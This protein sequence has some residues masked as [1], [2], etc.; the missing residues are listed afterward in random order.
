M[1]QKQPTLVIMAA[2]MGSRYGGLKQIDPVDN[3][4]NKIIDFSIYDAVQAGFAKV[5][6]II[7]EENQEAFNEAIADRLRG[8]VDIEFAYQKLED[9]PEGCKVPEGRVKPWGTAQAVLAARNLIDGPFAVINADDFYGREAFVKMH[10]FLVN[11]EDDEKYRYAMV[12]FI[13]K[14]TL[15]DNGYVSRGICTVSPENYLVSV[16]EHTHIEKDGEAAKYTEDDGKTW[17]SFSGNET[18]SMNFWGFGKSIVPELQKSFNEFLENLDSAEN[19]L[20]A[21]CYLPSVV[22]HLIKANQATAEVLTSNDKWFGV[23]YKED[24]P[25]VMASIQKLKDAGVY[26]EKLW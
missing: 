8:K 6:F 16:N 9:L 24:K 20:K 23:T 4:G 15:T 11:A 21:E 22:D 19:P 13:L 18:V 12:G 3:Y 5:I 14:N 25:D 10:D 1:K 26:P 17:N 7:K 2:G